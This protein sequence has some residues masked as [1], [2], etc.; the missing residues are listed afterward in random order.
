MGRASNV[1]IRCQNVGGWGTGLRAAGFLCNHGVALGSGSAAGRPLRV[2]K[3]P[4]LALQLF[5][6]RPTEGLIKD[7]DVLG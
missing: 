6:L 4:G 7:R 5:L 1:F 3:W 2:Q